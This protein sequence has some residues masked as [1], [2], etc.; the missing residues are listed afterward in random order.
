M[1]LRQ[2]YCVGGAVDKYINVRRTLMY[3]KKNLINLTEF[4]VF[5]NNDPNTWERVDNI[6]S[7]FLRSFWLSNGLAGDTAEQAFYVICDA[8]NNTQSS[9]NA[10]VLNVQVGD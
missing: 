4:A 5:E 8:T 6:I 9:I 3:L 7:Q 10:G 2:I 1:G